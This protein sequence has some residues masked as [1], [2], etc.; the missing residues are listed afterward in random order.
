MGNQVSSPAGRMEIG[1]LQKCSL[2]DYPGEICAVVFTR[3]CNFRCPYC[4]NP[5]LVLPERY[6]PL[7]PVRDIFAFLARRRGKL[8]AVTVTGGEPCIQPALAEFV[9][10]IR[11]NGFKVKIDT[12]GSLPGVLEDLLPHLDY[13]SMDIKAPPDK[14]SP[15]CGAKAAGEKIKKSAEII[16]NS[17]KEY[18]FRTTVMKGLLS[19]EDLKEIG[20][21]VKGASRFYIQN[22]LPAG[23]V[24]AGGGEKCSDEQ[25]G[26]FRDIL[27]EFVAVCRTR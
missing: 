17:C 8:D 4:Y 15:F 9:R 1:G 13:I 14:Y 12:N 2:I 20:E 22:Y 26:R 27:E 5:E 11:G 23:K 19:E 18:E 24:L 25:M 16:M 3:G 10:E 7:I 6:V 21:T